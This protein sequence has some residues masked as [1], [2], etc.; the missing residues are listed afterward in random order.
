VE[1]K[2]LIQLANVMLQLQLGYVMSPRKLIAR[3][4]ELLGDATGSTGI[5]LAALH[6]SLLLLA[7]YVPA[8]DT[9]LLDVRTLP[10]IELRWH[11][12]SS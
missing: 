5:D 1:L 11:N 6:A 8:E 7:T 12:G 10:R 4:S 9:D 2:I 3:A